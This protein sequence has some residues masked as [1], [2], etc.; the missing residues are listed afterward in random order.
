MPEVKTEIA[1]SILFL[2]GL[3]RIHRPENNQLSSS[4]VTKFVI[5]TDPTLLKTISPVQL[6]LR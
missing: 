3:T 5:S 1:R 6:K 2:S 4:S